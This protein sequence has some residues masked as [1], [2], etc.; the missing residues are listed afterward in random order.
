MDFLKY[1][2]QNKDASFSSANPV[3]VSVVHVVK[4]VTVTQSI[5]KKHQRSSH[6]R[7]VPLRTAMSW[8]FW[9]SRN[10]QQFLAGLADFYF[11]PGSSGNLWGF[12]SFKGGEVKR[13]HMISCN[14]WHNYCGGTTARD[15]F[16]EL[17]GFYFW[18]FGFEDRVPP[19]GLATYT[20]K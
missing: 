12:L 11:Y 17:T 3:F 8:D 16:A 6:L 20:Q 19:V 4:G 18:V 2:T 1:Q 15:F 5:Q 13:R 9:R 14:I 7:T 10:Q